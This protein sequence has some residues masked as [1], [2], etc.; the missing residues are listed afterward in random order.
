MTPP[1]AAASSSTLL[2]A[3]TS[4][5]N[6]STSSKKL[7][8]DIPVNYVASR[9]TLSYTAQSE[10]AQESETA[11]LTFGDGKWR[12]VRRVLFDD[13]VSITQV[14]PTGSCTA[15]WNSQQYVLLEVKPDPKVEDPITVQFVCLAEPAVSFDSKD[16]T[17]PAG[18]ESAKELELAQKC[19]SFDR[20]RLLVTY[21]GL[22]GTGGKQAS[23][24]PGLIRHLKVS[25]A[26]P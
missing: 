10:E 23:S 13:S 2:K 3:A 4:S 18:A 7:K 26:V 21:A 22:R 6:P 14:G 9:V 12:K 8:S 15:K 17:D 11:W 20:V 1:K 16:K 25:S 19:R 5:S 24:V